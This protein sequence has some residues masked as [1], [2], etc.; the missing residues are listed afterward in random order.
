MNRSF[1][2][3]LVVLLTATAVL[4][5]MVIVQ[6]SDM[7]GVALHKSARLFLGVWPEL[8]LGFLLAGLVDVLIPEAVLM[9]WPEENDFGH[10][11]SCEI[12]F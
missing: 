2:P 12:A 1:D 7:L 11:N 8:M 9:K 3:T 6:D 4:I 10:G 5:T